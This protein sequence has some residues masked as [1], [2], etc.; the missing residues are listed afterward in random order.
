MPNEA[1]AI[2]RAFLSHSWTDK[3]L[4]RRIARRLSHRGVPVWVDEN[5]M[6][7]GTVLSDRLTSEIRQSS[8]F[9]VLLTE[10]AG[11]SRWVAQE[12]EVARSQ[13]HIILLPLIAEEGIKTELLDQSLGISIAD[14]WTFEERLD[15]VAGAIL[16]HPAPTERNFDLLKKDLAAIGREAPEMR[17][18]IEQLL[19]TGRLTIAQLEALALDESQR[20]PAETALIAL[21]EC[22]V[23]DARYV[24]SLVA[25]TCFRRLGVGYEVMRRQIAVEP[26][27]SSHLHTMFSHLGDAVTRASDIEGARRLFDLASPPMDQAFTSFVRSNFDRFTQAQRDWAVRFITIPDRGPRAFACDAAFELYSRLPDNNS[28]RALW[29]FWINDYKFGGKDDA[30]DNQTPSM[31]FALMNEATEKGFTQFDAIMDHFQST[32]RRLTRAG[33]RNELLGAIGLLHSA[34]RSRYVRRVALANEL[35][36]AVHSAEWDALKHND[37]LVEEIWDLARAVAEDRP[38]RLRDLVAAFEKDP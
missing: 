5:E 8:H 15:T 13:P 30:E 10:A 4:A 24:L 22:A 12:T 19:Y 36:S 11:H 1:G 21:H 16:G 6:Q 32:F 17:G 34:A 27:G 14:P 9:L 28:L 25:A 35:E 20:H 38:F 37:A 33:K 7:I 18:L 3:A 31:F 23:A 2:T 26:A 29:F